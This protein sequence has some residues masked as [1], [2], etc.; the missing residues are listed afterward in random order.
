MNLRPIVITCLV[1]LLWLGGCDL[2][3]LPGQ[4]PD[5]PTLDDMPNIVRELGLPDLGSIP[6]LPDIADLPSLNLGPT[7]LGLT[8]PTERG[9]NVGERI[10]GTDIE[11]VGIGEGGA[12]F[13]IAG[14]RSLRRVGDSLDFTG[15]W[16]G[17]S[18]V[19]YTLRLRIYTIIGNSVRAAGVQQFV[20]HTISPSQ[21]TTAPQGNTIKIPYTA[22]AGPGQPFKGLTYRYVGQEERGAQIDGLPA[23]DY[24][25]FKVGDSVRWR[26]FLRPDLP[27]EYD[28]RVLFYNDSTLQLGGIATLQL[29]GQ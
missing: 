15:A 3:D 11:L 21:A 27:I 24:A 19:E 17:V 2:P 23:N 29:P 9:I 16:P 6:N 18:G 4:I 28:L 12:E 10:P 14:Q 1:A 26:G 7:A 13:R 20:I 25:F 22:A 5:L 8:G